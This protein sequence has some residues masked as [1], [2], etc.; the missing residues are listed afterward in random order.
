MRRY[1]RI[2]SAPSLAPASCENRS[3]CNTN[4]ELLKAVVANLDEITRLS[5][6]QAEARTQGDE[7][8]AT[9]LDEQL[10]MT[11]AQK[12]RSVGAWQ[13]HVREHGC[14][15]ISRSPSAL[16]GGQEG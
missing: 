14:T 10:D 16:K 5:K 1:N 4:R 15:G 11:Y 8:L 13:Q 2:S 7:A 6:A 3:V 12:E 9:R